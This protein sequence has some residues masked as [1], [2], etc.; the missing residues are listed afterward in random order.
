MSEGGGFGGQGFAGGRG[1]DAA[2]GALAFVRY[3]LLGQTVNLADTETGATWE[4]I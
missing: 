2:E 1:K 3:R 4:R